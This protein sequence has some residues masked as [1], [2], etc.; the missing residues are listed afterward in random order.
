MSQITLL[1][2]LSGMGMATDS[3]LTFPHY[4]CTIFI[5]R[6]LFQHIFP[7]VFREN[8]TAKLIRVST[9]EISQNPGLKL[10]EA[11][12]TTFCGFISLCKT[13]HSFS[14]KSERC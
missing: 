4:F 13:C 12:N 7:F 6:H 2:K 10:Y 14:M 3:L 9:M 5:Q 11:I 8:R 1:L